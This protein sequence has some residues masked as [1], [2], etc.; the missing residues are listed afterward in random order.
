[1]KN[2]VKAFDRDCSGFLFLWEKF[3]RKGREIHKTGIFDDP[4]IRE[5]MNHASFDESL[6]PIELSAWLALNPVIVNFLGN[7]RRSEYQKKGDELMKN[8]RRLGARMSVKMHFL[9]SHLDYFPENCGDF[10]EERSE[11][12][13]QDLRGMDERYQGGWDVKFLAD[14]CWCL[15]MDV[16]SAQH[17]REFLRTPF[18]HE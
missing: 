12:F 5:R 7:H 1:M 2:F 8:F 16:Q 11:R 4:E 18:L 17:K 9:R 3:K 14:Y 10:R 15:K 13:N 6:N